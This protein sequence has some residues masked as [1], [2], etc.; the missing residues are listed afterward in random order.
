[1]LGKD[2]NME[3]VISLTAIPPRFPYLGEVLGSLLA[4]TAPVKAVNLYLPRSYR[5]FPFDPAQL[6]AVPKG[7]EIRLCDQDYGPATKVLPAARD[8]RGQDVAILFCDDDKVYDP[9][10]AARYL[11]AAVAHPGCCIVEEGTDLP[12]PSTDAMRASHQ[13]RAQ[14][15]V[16]D[17]G[18]RLRRIA[19]FGQWKPRKAVA[20]G[21]VEI[22]EGWGGVLVL[23]EFFDD[24]AFDICDTCWM[25]DDIWLSGQLARRGIAIWLTAEGQLR[26][27]G[28]SDE[29]REAALR[30]QVIN[31]M[32]RVALNQAC[33]DHCR[34]SYGVWG[35][36][37][38]IDR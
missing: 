13:P 33:I 14:R 25:V 24:I 5:R 32:D 17:I 34:R 6:P 29:V 16:K 21:Y 19:S 20:S 28:N 18:Y 12:G 31:G 15:L 36:A 37:E 26:T 38:A 8:Y 35:G 27:R 23:P 7:V 1:M 22:L 10:W 2:D 4:Q 30:K 11:D 9:D 3:L